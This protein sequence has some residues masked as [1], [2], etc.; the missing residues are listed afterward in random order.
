MSIEHFVLTRF[1][2][3]NNRIFHHIRGDK[4]YSG[5][6]PLQTENLKKRIKLLRMVPS[7]CLKKQTTTHFKWIII[8]DPDIPGW[9]EKELQDIISDLKGASVFKVRDEFLNETEWI[10][11]QIGDNTE[12]LITTLLDDDDAFPRNYI[13]SIQ[14]LAKSSLPPIH[15][16]GN[17]QTWQWN[18]KYSE[19]TPIGTRTDWHR[20][21]VKMTACGFTLIT[22]YPA[23]PITVLGLMHPLLERYMDL[24]VEP[25]HKNVEYFQESVL[26]HAKKQSI[27]LT[28]YP[29][30]DFHSDLGPEVGHV[31]V[32]NHSA[33]D[34]VAR[35]FQQNLNEVV[36]E[37]PQTVPH[38]DVDW[39]LAFEYIKELGYAPE[40]FKKRK[41]LLS[42]Y[43]YYLKLKREYKRRFQ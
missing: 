24:N 30:V 8:T 22:H 41:R 27:D 37:G 28:Q 13:E 6:D 19:E 12:L 15:F 16:V 43:K 26:N 40:A 31:L 34:E 23:F 21:E 10:K 35:L 17:S 18:Y 4:W 14:Q 9:A 1:C 25:Q 33:N 29:T 20:P 11:P 3:R 42:I 38:I 32:S 36:M 39:N 5:K 2:I 7:V